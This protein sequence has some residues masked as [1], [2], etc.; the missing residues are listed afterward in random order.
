ML[1]LFIIF[2]LCD[3]ALCLLLLDLFIIL[4]LYQVKTWELNFCFHIFKLILGHI[5]SKIRAAWLV[6]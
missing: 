5:N 2:Y 6:D 3:H 4:G 1:F